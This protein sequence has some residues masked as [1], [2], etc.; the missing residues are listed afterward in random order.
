M[1]RTHILITSVAWNPQKWGYVLLCCVCFWPSPA[2]FSLLRLGFIL[3]ACCVSGSAAG[4]ENGQAAAVLSLLAAPLSRLRL[5]FPSPVSLSL[6]LS[7][8]LSSPPCRVQGQSRAAASQPHQWVG[9]VFCI[10]PCSLPSLQ[11][12]ILPSTSPVP[13]YWC[14]PCSSLVAET[15]MISLLQLRRIFL[16]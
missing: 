16:T 5:P 10:P 13:C 6:S 12:E 15:G 11:G 9:R 3:P 14:T 4:T 1:V 8:S 7:V 2:F